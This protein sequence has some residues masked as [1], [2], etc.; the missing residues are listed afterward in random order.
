MGKI[1]WSL[2]YT[3]VW[4]LGWFDMY[5]AFFS[6]FFLSFRWPSCLIQNK[7]LPW[8][9]EG[10]FKYRHGGFSLR[11]TLGQEADNR[12]K[13]QKQPLIPLT[14]GSPSVCT[15][16]MLSPTK[17][18]HRAQKMDSPQIY[19]TTPPGIHRGP[20]RYVFRP[21]QIFTTL[22]KTSNPLSQWFSVF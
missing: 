6:F 17:D 7:Q 1:H 20:S 14:P 9:K 13:L 18:N 11:F 8:E 19:G 21:F 2:D 12:P 5:S 3:R 10:R 22:L 15:S 16:D 4:F